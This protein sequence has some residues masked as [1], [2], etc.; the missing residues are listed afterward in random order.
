MIGRVRAASGARTDI[1]LPT[2]LP[3]AIARMHARGAID[4]V[5][6]D[7]LADV[8]LRRMVTVTGPDG[9]SERLGFGR[10]T[11]GVYAARLS[12]VL[13]ERV[14]PGWPDIV[15]Q[16]RTHRLTLE[17]MFNR[18]VAEF[19][20]VLTLT[21]HAH[22]EMLSLGENS[23]FALGGLADDCGVQ[24]YL[25]PVWQRL[26]RAVA[27]HDGFILEF[28]TFRERERQILAEAEAATIEF[29]STLGVTVDQSSDH[30]DE[31]FAL[32]IDDPKR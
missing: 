26:M 21:A 22:A 25:G 24:L 3:K 2:A 27:D 8:T 29:W 5:C 9:A 18:I 19:D 1:R 23:P 16:Y 28:A 4:E 12:D 14:H 10:L 20:E 31:P 13:E 17:E 11:G 30:P 6:C 15:Q 7:L 32:W